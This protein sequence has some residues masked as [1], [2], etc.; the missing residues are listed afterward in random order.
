[1]TNVATGSSSDKHGTLAR[2]LPRMSPLRIVLPIIRQKAVDEFVNLVRPV[3]RDVQ[4]KVNGLEFFED[5]RHP[6][7]ERPQVEDLISL[8]RVTALVVDWISIPERSVV[9]VRKF[10]AGSLRSG[11]DF[12][13]S[14]I[15]RK[16]QAEQGPDGP[17][18]LVEF[19]FFPHLD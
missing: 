16:E 15:I 10:P 18:K 6:R 12:I 8:C 17:P 2:R 7:C 11:H 1:M 5:R 3:R 19:V 9:N 13:K 14:R 4:S